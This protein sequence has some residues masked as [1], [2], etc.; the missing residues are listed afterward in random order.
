M[1]ACCPTISESSV[2]DFRTILNALVLKCLTK[3]VLGRSVAE[4]VKVVVASEAVAALEVVRGSQQAAN[5]QV[6]IRAA[7]A[8]M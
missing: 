2:F 3:S 8:P 6:N 5:S 7:T 4:A 1:H